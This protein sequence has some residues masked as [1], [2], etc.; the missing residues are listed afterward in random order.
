MRYELLL[1]AL[2]LCAGT[3]SIWAG[4]KGEKRMER[5]MER[6][7]EFTFIEDHAKELNLTDAQKKELKALHEKT[8]DAREKMM[9]SPEARA[10]MEE[11]REARKSGDEEK[12]KEMRQKMMAEMQKDPEHSPAANMGQ[13]AKILNPEQLA[14]LRELREKEGRPTMADMKERRKGE[15]GEKAAEKAVANKPDPTRG[16]PSLYDNEK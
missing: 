1:T 7:N 11:M 16:V 3:C 9:K 5:Q 8:K 2:V 6:N 15:R 12:L 4:D 13:I 10:N 14:K